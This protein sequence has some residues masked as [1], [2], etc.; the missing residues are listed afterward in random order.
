MQITFNQNGAKSGR[1]TPYTRAAA[2]CLR[3]L[4]S[5]TP[6][7]GGRVLFIMIFLVAGELWLRAQ[8]AVC[9]PLLS[10]LSEAPAQA[11]LNESLPAHAG[12]Q[13]L[14]EAESALQKGKLRIVVPKG[15]VWGSANLP[16]SG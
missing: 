6:L 16:A 8:A 1:G 13:W 5:M 15:S 10:E 11:Y 3:Y 7:L 4:V 9:Q 2:P 12:P 14:A